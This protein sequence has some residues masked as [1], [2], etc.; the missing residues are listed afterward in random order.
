MHV[1][2]TEEIPFTDYDSPS[3]L[4]MQERNIVLGDWSPRGY[5]SKNMSIALC[6]PPRSTFLP[7]LRARLTLCRSPSLRNNGSAYL[8]IVFTPANLSPNP[9]SPHHKAR[10]TWSIT[11]RALPRRVEFYTTFLSYTR[12]AIVR[13]LPKQ[14][15]VMR[16]NLMSGEEKEVLIPVEE[17]SA[18]SAPLSGNKPVRSLILKR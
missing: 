4:V 18:I 12:V 8:F 9:L 13:Y 10:L 6:V 1:Y 16:K 15:S 2:L 17:P 7:P 11:H 5:R 3:A 14:K